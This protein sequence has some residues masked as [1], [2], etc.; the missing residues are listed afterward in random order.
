M[1]RISSIKLLKS[2][3]EDD[4]L[5]SCKDN[6][7]RCKNNL[8]KQFAKLGGRSFGV[9]QSKEIDN[10]FKC[11][12]EAVKIKYFDSFAPDD[13]QIPITVIAIG[14]Y[15]MNE[16]S[17]KSSIDF[18]ISYKNVPGY[19]V[20]LI[21]ESYI[22]ILKDINLYI[23]Y[24]IY[25]IDEMF[26][27]LKGDMELKTMFYQIRFVCASKQ[28][29]KLTRDKINELKEYKKDEFIKFHLKELAP[30]DR[31]KLLNQK[32][33]LK[34]GYGG[35]YDYKRIFWLLN[36]IDDNTPKSHAL[37]VI[38]EKEI[39]EI[40]LAADFI[41][42][43]R[44]ALHISGGSDE[45]KSE[46]LHEV[47]DVMQTKEKKML[48]TDILL[49]TKALTCMQTIGVYSRY[50]AKSLFYTHFSSNLSFFQKRA[51]RLKNGFYNISSTVYVP[52][53]AKSKEI[54]ALIKD[55]N[56][57]PD[58]ELKFDITTIFYMKRSLIK[59]DSIEKSLLEF[60]KIF[61]RQHC[62][63]ILNALLDAELLFLFVRPM[64]HTRHLAQLDDYHKY[65]VDEYSL[66]CVYHLENI[67]DKFIKSLHDDLC[68]DGKTL[69]K[70]VALMHDVG[71]GLSGDHLI[72][73][74]NI[75]RAYANKLK[76]SPKAINMGITLIKTHT[77]MNN[78]ANREDIYNEQVILNFIS[79]F[80]DKQ[81][82]KLLYILTYCQIN[83]T[84]DGFYNSYNAKLLR[85]LYEIAMSSFD[86]S[87]ANLLDEASRRT[88]KIALIKKQKE[89]LELSK[90]KQE[91]IFSIPSN[92]L[93][94]KYPPS[95]IIRIALFADNCSNIAINTNNKDGFCIEII[96]KRGWNVSMVLSK[97]A[98]L[99]LAYMEIFELFDNKCFVKL[100]YNNPASIAE[101]QNLEIII[102]AAL[103][104]KQRA[105]TTKPVILENEISFDI[106]HSE[107]YAKINI[108]AKDQRGL[109]A[110]ILEVFEEF[111]IKVANARIQTIKN[112]TRNLFLIQ[113]SDSLEA[114]YKKI[115]DL[116]VTK[117]Q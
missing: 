45:L 71:K 41:S 69:I 117:D 112:R 63:G 105:N 46:F 64:E 78:V 2:K 73:G 49:V 53:H 98:H 116:I 108:N 4:I 48:G 106:N 6:V 11:A 87:E 42:S 102:M 57:L 62:F 70:L 97:L 26:D 82:I 51:S 59:K 79:N 60:K 34:K 43:L 37:K 61:H 21:V 13:D 32:P 9:Y 25:E 29:Y 14:S 72:T 80:H 27:L 7:L 92:L 19:N 28:L 12:F 8:K 44:S 84:N 94:I 114:N 58:I 40:N 90:D 88:K 99:D 22:K 35:F 30:Y 115:L 74:A 52:K 33:D 85:E 89:F 91:L 18:F 100:E 81:A 56:R 113:K 55:I 23:N 75:F 104:D 76:L 36:S 5:Q 38:S 110:Y 20:R 24:K 95:E 39:S 109:M 83:A 65:S 66:L 54:G 17:V 93:F 107:I 96:T 68:S 111:D 3:D 10:F 15:G 16:M 101:M 86:K 47:C 31:I 50:L 1:A 103:C 67:N 77:L